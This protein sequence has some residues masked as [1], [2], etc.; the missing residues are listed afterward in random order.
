MKEKTMSK[1]GFT[2]GPCP[3]CNYKESKFKE[4]LISEKIYG[5]YLE[6]DCPRC[7]NYAFILDDFDDIHELLLSIINEDELYWFLGY[8]REQ[9]EIR[10]YNIV[11]KLRSE[12]GTTESLSYKY[13]KLRNEPFIRIAKDKIKEQIIFA[14]KQAPKT[15]HDKAI[16][17]LTNLANSNRFPGNL[18]PLDSE[19][20]YTA[21]YSGSAEEFRYYL[22]YLEK[23]DYIDIRGTNCIITVNGWKVVNEV[24]TMKNL[25]QCFVAMWF[26]QSMDNI[27][28]KIEKAIYEA[29]YK[30]IRVDKEHYT[31]DVTDKIIT[32]IRKSKF[33][34]ADYTGQRHGVYYEAGFARGLGIETISTCKQDDIKNLHFDTSHLNHIPWET[35]E[36]LYEK[37]KDRILAIYGEGPLKNN[38]NPTNN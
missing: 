30:P 16:K 17:L 20:D 24:Q 1:I 25:P 23:N 33:I 36:L 34:V 12:A 10:D 3:V 18:I 35:E 14:I 38:D 22:E 29:G 5:Q 21:S 9:T 26:D 8:T 7:G 27:Y 37:L 15:P 6:I 13:N 31:G 28:L 11:N 32:E 4:A 2:E 19:K